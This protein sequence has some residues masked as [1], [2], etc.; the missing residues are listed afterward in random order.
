MRAMKRPPFDAHDY[1][2][3][4]EGSA[5]ASEITARRWRSETVKFR[6][7]RLEQIGVL[8]VTGGYEETHSLPLAEGRHF[9]RRRRTGGSR[10]R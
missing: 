10:S 1:N 4:V 2:M 7:H 5:A 6:S 9:L 8:G 3:L